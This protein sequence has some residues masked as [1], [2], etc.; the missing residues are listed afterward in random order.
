[1]MMGVFMAVCLAGLL[2][3][4]IGIGD[5]ILYKQHMQDG[6]DAVAYAAAVY[7]ARGMN[8]IAMLNIIM[9]AILA[10]LVGLKLLQLLNGLAMAISCL[11]AL[12]PF[13][14]AVFSAVCSF[15]SNLVQPIKDAI[16]AVQEVVDGVLPVLSGT[17]KVIGYTFPW[18]AEVKA[19]SVAAD[20][21]KPIT[22]GAMVSPSLIPRDGRQGLPVEED[23][24][25]TLCDK[26]TENVVD[27]IFT[28]F[29]KGDIIDWIKDKFHDG[30]KAMGGYFCGSGGGD[31]GA[32]LETSDEEKAEIDK[33]CR[34]SKSEWESKTSECTSGL[35]TGKDGV[36]KRVNYSL[37]PCQG[38][39]SFVYGPAHCPTWDQLTEAQREK[40]NNNT[41]KCSECGKYFDMNKC[42]EDKQKELEEEKR[43]EFD[44]AMTEV[45]GGDDKKTPKKI[46][47]DAKNG[48]SYFQIWSFVIGDDHIP[49]SADKGVAL[50]AWEKKKD[51]STAAIWGKVSIAQAEFYFDES[52]T[53]ANQQDPMWSLKWRARMR[54]LYSPEKAIEIATGMDVSGLF[55]TVEKIA[56]TAKSIIGEL[57]AM[58]EA[59]DD[60][61]DKVVDNVN[62]IFPGALPDSDKVDEAN[63]FV[64]KLDVDIIH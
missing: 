51:A 13:A 41:A 32:L 48:Q 45:T 39:H 47:K 21:D 52:G 7:H 15:T 63:R 42:K 8:M 46:Y 14:G 12:I 10:V 9:A 53:F 49:N 57:S 20:Y 56:E 58:L 62:T 22:F 27:L 33:A 28:P 54:R 31:P 6:A 2:W 3:Y 61:K 60:V 38:T 11:L 24:F 29:P 44:N 36:E 17:Q 55:T 16:D 40:C 26:G 37:A 30:M 18:L 23:T 34:Q 43:K 1:M 4:L 50:A 25:Q 64:K 5:T 35:V 59:V 19:I